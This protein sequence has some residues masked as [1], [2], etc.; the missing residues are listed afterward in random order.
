MALAIECRRGGVRG[1][2]Q[3]PASGAQPITVA[4]AVAHLRANP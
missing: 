1:L 4:V 2:E 3:S